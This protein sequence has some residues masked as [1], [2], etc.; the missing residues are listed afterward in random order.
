MVS[1]AATKLELKIDVV[2]LDCPDP[3][4]LADFYARLL[5]WPTPA[6]EDVGDDWVTLRNPDGGVGL[7]FQRAADYQA[8]TWPAPTLPQMFHLDLAVSDLPA[9][10]AHALAVGART[11]DVSAEHPTFQVYADPA[12]HP[13]CL[14]AC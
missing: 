11:L 14:C 12:G 5:D 2:V 10:R 7:A 8:P 3:V 13:F 1:S 4:A 6:G 9:S